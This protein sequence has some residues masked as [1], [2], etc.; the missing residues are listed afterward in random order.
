MPFD[1]PGPQ[2]RRK[3]AVVGGGISGLGAALALADGDDVTLFEAEDRLGGH[4]RTVFAGKNIDIPIDTGFIVYNDRNYPNLKA[5]FQMLDVPTKPSDMSFAATFDN[6]RLEY[7]LRGAR[8]LFAQKRNLVRPAYYAMV[9]DILRFNRNAHLALDRPE[10]TLGDFLDEL[11]LGKPFRDWYVL[12]FSGAIWS[13]TPQE[14]LSFPAASFVQ[15]FQNHGLLAARGQPAWRTVDG[16]SRAYVQRLETALRQ[17]GVTIRLGASAEAVI[18]GERPQLAAAGEAPEPFDAVILASH[19][20]QSLKLLS[21]TDAE[22]R[23]ILGALRYKSNHAVLHDDPRLMPKRRACW[24]SWNYIG[25]GDRSAIGVTYWM[26]RLQTLPTPDQYFVTLNPP[27]DIPD[28]RIVDTYDF[29]HPQFDQAAIDAQA[30]LPGIQGRGGVYFAG[31]YA[32]YGFHE[33]GLRSGLE[34]ARMLG[35]TPV[36]A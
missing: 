26:N 17:K 9:R 35:A 7:G 33:D 36:W 27:V 34:A 11:R 21:S 31:A 29:A 1:R 12:P 4:A 16:G 8:A 10:L 2:G 13:A 22:Q 32:K 6:G 3:I 24:S 20:D 23:R 15:F 19:A 14:M 18:P 28:E 5:L 25:A 30:T